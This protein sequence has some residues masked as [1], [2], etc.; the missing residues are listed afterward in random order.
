[1]GSARLLAA[2][3]PDF[4][5]E[6]RPIFEK[7][8]FKCHGTE[9][10][11]GGLRF[12]LKVGAFKMGE[13]GERAIVPKHA[14]QSRMIKLVTSLKDDE[15][16]PPKGERL[17]AKEVDVLKRWIDAGAN[18]PETAAGKNVARAEMVVTDEDRQYWAFRGLSSPA[19][20]RVKNAKRVRT[21]V[22][23]FVIARLEQ[24]NLK[25]SEEA[26]AQKIVRRIYFDLVGLPPTPAQVDRKSV[27]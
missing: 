22:D 27:V 26:S 12:D 1:M 18:W 11:K 10:Q 19:L 20:P 9:K 6:V 4:V 23:R 3:V 17:A 14:D 2:D 25:L 13:S 24:S 5:R 8:C 7:H 21:P 15:W 16:M